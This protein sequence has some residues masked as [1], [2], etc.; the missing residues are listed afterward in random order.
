[1]DDGAGGNGGGIR[2]DGDCL[3]EDCIIDGNEAGF[4]G[5]PDGNA[6]GFGGN[7]GNGGGIF[8]SGTLI[9]DEC[10]IG[11]NAAGLGASG[12][13]SEGG[14]DGSGGNGGSGNGYGAVAGGSGGSG[15]GICTGGLTT[16]TSCTITLNV[17]GAGGNAGSGSILSLDG[18]VVSGP[19][20]GS[21]GSGGGILNDADTNSVVIR[22]SL[23]VQ[24]SVNVG[25]EPG[26][27]YSYGLAPSPPVPP[28]ITIQMAVGNPGSN[29]TGFDLA[30]NFTSQGCDLISTGDGSTGF[31]NGVMADQVG[32][33]ASPIDPQLGPL[34]MNGGF[35]PTHALLWGSP[36]IDQGKCFGVHTDQ[37]GRHR[38]YIYSSIPR[39]H[40]GDGS[41]IGAFELDVRMN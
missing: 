40:G 18:Q 30:G 9:V 7:G 36:A 29:G 41:D 16:L 35:M 8:N 21:G 19:S 13:D 28:P 23:I 3:L 14:P 1:L 10:I 25:G 31:T 12:G 6:G 5:Y 4:G 24:N 26:T 38:P 15:G 2:N 34:Q 39:P 37:R 20:G 11:E 27:N 22:N 32:T 17:C 33:D